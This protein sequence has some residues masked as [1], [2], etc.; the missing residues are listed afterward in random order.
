MGSQ[1]T[2]TPLAFPTPEQSVSVP[3]SVS[4]SQKQ[5]RKARLSTESLH[6]SLQAINNSYKD[7]LW[8]VQSHRKFKKKSQNNNII[9]AFFTQ[10]RK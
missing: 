3:D 4:R 5:R 10:K 6:Y 9:T 2:H 1:G 8:P 7:W